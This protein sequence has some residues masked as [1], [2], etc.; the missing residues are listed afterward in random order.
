MGRSRMVN[1][2]LKDGG[3]EELDKLVSGIEQL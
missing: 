2:L 1:G 3:E